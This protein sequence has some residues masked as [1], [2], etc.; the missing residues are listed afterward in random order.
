MDCACARQRARYD[1]A[2]RSATLAVWVTAATVYACG[3][4]SARDAAENVQ[5]AGEGTRF[6]AGRAVDAAPSDATP[7]VVAAN[8]FAGA[9]AVDATPR[10]G[11]PLG[12]YGGRLTGSVDLDPTNDVTLFRPS[13]GVRDKLWCKALVVSNG[14]NKV[15]FLSVDG[16]GV[17]GAFVQG[18]LQRARPKGYS[19]AEDDTMVFASHT[20]SG[21]G[22]VTKLRFWQLAAMDLHV[23]RAE[24]D[25]T[26]SC[27]TALAQAEKN[28]APAVLGTGVVALRGVV[29]N[30]RASRSPHLEDDTIDPDLA[31]LRVDRPNGAPVA[32]LWNYAVHGT[33]LGAG[34]LKF[35]ADVMGQASSVIE[36]S[37]PGVVALFANGAE[38]D[39]SPNSGGD[40]EQTLTVTGTTIGEK[41]VAARLGVATRGEVRRLASKS[42]RYD[43]GQPRVVIDPSATGELNLGGLGSVLG[44]LPGVPVNLGADFMDHEF[45]V[46]AIR[47]DDD[48]FVSV[49]GEALYDVGQGLKRDAHGLG[50][51][52]VFLVGL[53]N[54][55][56]GYIPSKREYDLGGYEVQVTLFGDQ[57]GQKVGDACRAQLGAVR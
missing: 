39:T 24:D 30:R 47:L 19:L 2:M 55:H 22:A 16:I 35:S 38:G 10:I 52:N 53:A 54:G 4:E 26:E 20:H 56:M 25:L 5:D 27:A 31:V 18:V 3:S 8:V 48:V 33:A 37:L 12:G 51:R 36:R 11:A 40:D 29:H 1:G 15:S 9:A 42:K 46:Q 17:I 45:R 34:N 6:D 23:Q 57:T 13:T 14:P 49:P 32:V 50:F 7:D 41:V 43:F 21:V 28:L 44:A